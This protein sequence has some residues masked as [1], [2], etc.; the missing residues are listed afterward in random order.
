MRCVVALTTLVVF[1]GVADAAPRPRG[2]FAAYIDPAL[3]QRRPSQSPR[4]LVE[5]VVRCTSGSSTWLAAMRRRLVRLLGERRLASTAMQV[6]VDCVS[7]NQYPPVFPEAEPCEAN[8]LPV[9]PATPDGLVI[10]FRCRAPTTED[11][12]AVIRSRLGPRR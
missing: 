5:F 1:L 10:D 6:V 4:V 11:V 2:R 12:A 3:V 8:L 9:T 7:G